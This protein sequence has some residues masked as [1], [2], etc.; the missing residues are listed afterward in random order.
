VLTTPFTFIATAEVV[1]LLGAVPVFVDIEEATCNIDP[2]G[3]ERCLRAL[4]QGD[5]SV[6]PLPR[7]AD[8]AG[9]ARAVI[10]VDLFG[11]PADYGRI[12]QIAEAHGLEVI[13][14]A[15][16]SFGG[17]LDG[18]RCGA[19]ARLAAT[20]FFPAKPLGC[21]GDGGAVF[22]DDAGLDAV[23]RSVRV[24]G[25][26]EDRYENVR[27]GI[28]GR[29][30]TLQAAILSIKLARF[31]AELQARQRLAEEYTQGLAEVGGLVLPRVPDVVTSA[32]AQYSIRVRQGGA[33]A[34]DALCAALK[35]R[36]VP[37]AI[38]YPKPLHLQG[39]FAHLGYGPGDMPVSEACSQAI[40][41]LPF[42]PWMDEDTPGRVVE[43]VRGAAREVL[44]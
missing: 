5:P 1:A 14:D 43:A 44:G 37:T 31:P 41:S 4:A 10:P 38:Y 26:G 9:P 8:L 23:L 30:D 39:A 34:R 36:G 28:N 15:A 17:A 16:Q 20:S 2:A 22:T 13:E 6:Y 33:E 24:H 27:V 18:R 21:Y 29:M 32:W 35:E 12:H 40:F 42:H 11:V 19:L 25:M 7:G 3:L